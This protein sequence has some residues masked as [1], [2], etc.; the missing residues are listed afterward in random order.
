[1]TLIEWGAVANI[2]SAVA[3]LVILLIWL[4]SRR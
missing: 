2:V 1:M 3:L 4:G